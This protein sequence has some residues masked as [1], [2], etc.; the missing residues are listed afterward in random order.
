MTSSGAWR[1]V[2]SSKLSAPWAT[3]TSSPSTV[4]APCAWRSREQLRGSGAVDQVDDIGVLTDLIERQ[5][6]L[7]ERL[8]LSSRAFYA[9]CRVQA[10]GGAVDE[11]IGG[12]GARARRARRARARASRARSGVRF[13]TDTSLAPASRSAHTAARALPPAPSTSARGMRGHLVSGRARRSGR[14]RRCS[15]RRSS[16]SAANVSVLAAPIS[17]AAR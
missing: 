3:S 15:R 11:Q 6:E 7:V 9:G 12:V 14:G 17:R 13:Q 1:P 8:I 2:H 16:P 10:D 4:R 5:S